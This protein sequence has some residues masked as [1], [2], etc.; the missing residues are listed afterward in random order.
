MKTPFYA[1]ETI[2]RETTAEEVFRSA[3]DEMIYESPQ[4]A[5]CPATPPHSMDYQWYEIPP[6]EFI[7][8]LAVCSAGQAN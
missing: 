5:A 4:S 8:L 2:D 1:I 6:D 3:E 7:S